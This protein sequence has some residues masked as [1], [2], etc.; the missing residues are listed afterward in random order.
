MPNPVVHFEIG[1]QNRESTAAFYEKLFAWTMFPNEIAIEIQT[2][3][4]A[5]VTGHIVSLGHAPFNYTQF[6]VE[7]ADLTAT[8]EQAVTLG[9]KIIVP[10]VPRP[11]GGRFAW[12]QDPEGNT[13]GLIEA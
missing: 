3:P 5:T 7:V 6:Y 1:C 10:P 2:D 12:F 8:L 13:V 4:D 9:G 11:T